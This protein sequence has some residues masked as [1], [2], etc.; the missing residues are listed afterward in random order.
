MTFVVKAA[1]ILLLTLTHL[2][3]AKMSV[4]FQPQITS[5]AQTI[6]NLLMINNDRHNW[7]TLPL[8][9]HP[10]AGEWLTRDTVLA[11][12][13]HQTGYTAWQWQ[14]KTRI[15]VKTPSTT[16][17]LALQERAKT[18]LIK[19]LGNSY[20]RIEV[21][22]LSTINNSDYPLDSFTTHINLSWPIAKR[23]VVWLTNDKEKI[24]V[25]FRIKAYHQVMM[26]KDVIPAGKPL[27]TSMFYHKIANIAGYP[28][29][30]VTRLPANYGLTTKL[31]KDAI[32][33][34]NQLKSMPLVHKG[35]TISVCFHHNSVNIFMD[36]IALEDADLH[37]I[38]TIKNPQNQ[39]IFSA[40]I[41]DIKHAEAVI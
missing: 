11:W 39:Q 24:A 25:W 13:T 36:G 12:L 4:R 21:N 34:N 31:Q 3:Y 29:P 38:I 17:G 26:A 30:P 32:L 22:P 20:Q 1:I 18:A 5:Q 33:F 15:Q 41:T 10:V 16:S 28:L 35:Q 7:S 19:Q 14:G 6:G 23:V 40:K 9:S 37:Q 8:A 2:T 27:M